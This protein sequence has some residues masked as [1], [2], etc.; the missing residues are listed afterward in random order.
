MPTA[1]LT[2]GPPTPGPTSAPESLHTPGVERVYP[3]LRR[4]RRPEP[5]PTIYYL[6]DPVLVHAM[7]ELERQGHTQRF[8]QR[9]DHDPALRRRLH[10]DH[11]QY[12]SRRWDMLTPEDR[13]LI[14]G[15]PSL[16]RAFRTGVAGVANFDRINCLHAHSAH[17]LVQRPAG[18]TL[19]G[20]LIDAALEQL[21]L[22]RDFDA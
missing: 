1:P 18:G 5:F 10:D 14:R 13:R 3:L 17:H 21:P 6:R 8:Q 20:Q 2:P 16:G 7:S 22:P 15:A 4:G 19:I 11:A 12:R 9:L